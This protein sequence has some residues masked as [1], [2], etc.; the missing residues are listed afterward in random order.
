MATESAFDKKLTAETAIDQVEGLLE[1]FN[2]PP[3]AIA[4]IR[5][6]MR[7]IQ[8]GLGIIAIGVVTWSL[9]GSYAERRVEEAASSLAVAI[10]KSDDEKISALQQVVKEYANTTS[11]TWAEIE[12]AHSKMAEAQ[13]DQAVD[14]YKSI[15]ENTKSDNA[16]Y[17]LVVY[18][19]AQ[20]FEGMGNY[21][22]SSGQYNILKDIKGYEH[23]GYSGMGRVEEAAGDT[24]KAIAIYNNFILAIGDD[25]SFSQAKTEMEAK[26][27][28]LKALK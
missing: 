5:K 24:E 20:G 12:L 18:G 6:N 23:I 13:Y 7:M 15:L 26:I 14:K 16:L 21:S 28:R 19:I 22:E 9:Y 11:A 1:H 4:Y 25:P 8:I 3:R 27:A 2:L 10:Q 17:P